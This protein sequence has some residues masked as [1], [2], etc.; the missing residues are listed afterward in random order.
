MNKKA[1]HLPPSFSLAM[2]CMKDQCSSEARRV[3]SATLEDPNSPMQIVFVNFKVQYGGCPKL[4][5]PFWGP[6]N[7]YVTII[8]RGLYWGPLI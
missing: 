5:V 1:G 7:N 3:S 2:S 8:C 6:Y 4:R